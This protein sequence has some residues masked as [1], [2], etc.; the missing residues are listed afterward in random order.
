[1][2]QYAIGVA[3]LYSGG[4]SMPTFVAGVMRGLLIGSAVAVICV[5]AAH[6]GDLTNAAPTRGAAARATAGEVIVRFKP[7]A[8]ASSRSLAIGAVGAT[9]KRSLLL[10]QTE[11]V[12][13]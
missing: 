6:A 9:R 10:P 1:M 8:S 5:S 7:G 2:R 12:S 3:R 11:V 13:V 4:K